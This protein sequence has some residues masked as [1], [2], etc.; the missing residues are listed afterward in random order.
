MFRET[1]SIPFGE[2]SGQNLTLNLLMFTYLHRLSINDWMA[3]I[4]P[5]LLP[6]CA[7]LLTKCLCC[8]MSSM[9]VL[10]STD[11]T[12]VQLRAQ[13]TFSRHIFAKEKRR[14]N[15]FSPHNR[16]VMSAAYEAALTHWVRDKIA[17]ISQTTFY[18]AFSWMKIYAFRLRFHWGLLLWFKLT[19]FKHSFR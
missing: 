1:Q 15:S 4:S 11:H 16:L 2:L 3:D 19:V 9:G 13:P 18:I 17:A 5:F 14:V 8:N 10:R 7:T 6:L 12:G